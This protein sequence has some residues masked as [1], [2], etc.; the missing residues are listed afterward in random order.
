MAQPSRENAR[1]IW[2]RCSRTQPTYRRRFRVVAAA[3][4]ESEAGAPRFKVGDVVGGV[5]TSV[6]PK[7]A[8][9]DLGGG[10]T[11]LLTVGQISSAR[12]EGGA[13]QVLAEGDKLKVLVIAVQGERVKLSTK[14]QQG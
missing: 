3:S 6:Q 11:G 5:I 1:G 7:A 4:R 14:Q 12:F 8:L 10:A 9:V 2:T 13:G